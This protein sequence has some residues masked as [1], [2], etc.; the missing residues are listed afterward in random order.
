[1]LQSDDPAAPASGAVADGSRLATAEP[2]SAPPAATPPP[3]A[4]TVPPE[5]TSAPG[6][7]NKPAA[8]TVA[9]KKSAEPPPV[10]KSAAPATEPAAAAPAPPPVKSAP[11]N[12]AVTLSA[13]YPFEV[14]DG[15]RLLSGAARSHE[16]P[17]QANGKTLRIVATDVFLDQQVRVDGGDDQ[18]FDHAAP[19]LGRIEIRAAR[20]ECKAM[21][22]KK[23]LGYGPWPPQN[24]VVGEH[25]VTLVC[26]DDQ[27][28]V[29]H[30]LVT[31]GRPARATF[32]AK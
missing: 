14:W 18:R 17:L 25:R 2:V 21:V 20:G 23:D 32:Q 24:A 15:S 30:V 9:T 4:A 31:Q 22:G 10:K 5:T 11:A 29:Q 8:P 27:N 19:G 13:T 3:A 16:L 12:V 28:P 6:A 7:I 26:P 1:M